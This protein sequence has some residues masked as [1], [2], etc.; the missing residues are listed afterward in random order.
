MAP[1]LI[2]R[3]NLEGRPRDVPVDVIVG[4]VK[5]HMPEYG[6][7][8]LAP[9]DRV[10]VVKSK[11]GSGKST[12]LPAHLFR[13]LRDPSTPKAQKF[14]GRSLMCTQPRVLTAVR[15]ARDMAGEGFYPELTFPEVLKGPDG[16]VKAT[17][18]G[19]IGY[20]TGE[21]T[22]KP[23][24]G[25]I[26][27]TAGV[28]LVQLRAAFAQNDWSLV[29]SKYAII[30]VDEAHEQSIETEST[31]SYL[32]MMIKDGIKE[33][34]NVAKNLPVVLLASATIDEDKYVSYFELGDSAAVFRVSGRQFQIEKRWPTAGTNDYMKEAATVAAK[35]HNEDAFDADGEEIRDVLIF[36]PGA[37]ETRKTVDELQKMRKRGSLDDGGPVIF[38]TIN[39]TV[40]NTQGAA[41][42]LLTAPTESLWNALRSDPQSYSADRIDQME[43][44]FTNKKG[45]PVRRIIVSTVVAETGLTV[46]TLRC[47]IDS[48][49]NRSLE[50]YYGVK[51]LLTK[52]AP[53]SRIEQRM[54]RAG[55]KGEGIFMPLYTEKVY[56]EL[57]KQQEPDVVIQGLGASALDVFAVAEKEGAF[58][59]SDV[60]MLNVPPVD[61]FAESA[62]QLMSLGYVSRETSKITKLGRQAMRFPRLPLEARRMWQGAALW[63]CSGADVATAIAISAVCEGRGLSTLLGRAKTAE[64]RRMMGTPKT[65]K[66]IASIRNDILTDYTS[67]HW[68][69][70]IGG[71]TN[72]HVEKL[73]NFIRNDVIEG[74]IL[75]DAWEAQV[76]KLHATDKPFT[77]IKE[78]TETSGLSFDKIIEV[79]EAREAAIQEA[80]QAGIN[81]FWC[82]ENKLSNTPRSDNR[83]GTKEILAERVANLSQ[84][85]YDA[86]RHKS[87]EKQTDGTEYLYKGRFP[88]Q[89]EAPFDIGLKA[90]T[91][92]IE[93]RRSK[94][95]PFG[96]LKWELTAPLVICGSAVGY[97][98]DL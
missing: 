56:N 65:P 53:R 95:A 97:D 91:P 50:T 57:P 31:L 48:G 76:Q 7:V 46:P 42:G 35:F 24:R 20:Q 96:T 72:R 89:V 90:F 28:L 62:Q 5:R 64:V 86:Y 87:I 80:I 40:V 79:A 52:P 75:Y 63:D 12:V 23:P 67:T 61:T 74:I 93:M 43:N 17:R 73:R 82:E 71:T 6:S 10:A 41:F 94:E 1:T 30:V 45:P 3:G 70:A 51:A 36:M 33:G 69:F 11:T 8:P 98:S 19:T 38:L 81:P 49:W 83:E 92:S 59:P 27:A 84:C 77:S 15:L 25:L 2:V 22:S 26:Y 39:S 60:D 54:G 44:D 9:S 85:M 66:E 29:T 14:T 32:K 47:V 58:S 18:G 16:Q 88:V 13:L 4:W 55:R 37:Q 78:W 34:G 21:I 68:W